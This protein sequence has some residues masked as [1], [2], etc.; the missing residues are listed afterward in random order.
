MNL[1]ARLL[2]V[3]GLTASVAAGAAE[4]AAD[5]DGFTQ[6]EVVA[7]ATGFFGGASEGLAQVIEKAF[8][9][10]GRPTAYIAGEEV[11]GAIGVG[12]RY[13]KGRLTGKSGGHRQVYWQGPSI[14][15]D[16]GGDAAKVFVLVYNLRGDKNA[17]FQ[18]FPG[19]EGSYYFV[20]GVGLHYMQA[21]GI[22]LAPIRTGV[23]LRAGVNIGYMHIT[24]K[25]SWV[26][27]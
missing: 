23:G 4:R 1:F 21:N 2:L 25:E 22:V 27:F 24:P 10:N 11:S 3:L 7:A 16:F 12:V 17:I 19:I 26:P 8:Q 6:N 14:G 20:A 13:G 9:D 5:K 15:F 18:R